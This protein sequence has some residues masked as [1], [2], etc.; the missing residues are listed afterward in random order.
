MKD[1]LFNPKL[2]FSRNRDFGY[3]RF[4]IKMK[5]Y[6]SCILLFIVS[7]WAMLQNNIYFVYFNNLIK[8]FSPIKKKT[9]SIPNPKPSSKMRKIKS[10]YSLVREFSGSQLLEFCPWNR[11]NINIEKKILSTNTFLSLRPTERLVTIWPQVFFL[12]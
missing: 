1:P 9:M 12:L 10:S 7:L 11:M 5:K 2:V 3:K 6:V 8:N 4:P